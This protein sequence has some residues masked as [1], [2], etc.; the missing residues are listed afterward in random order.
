M[1]PFDVCLVLLGT[2]LL[3]AGGEALVRN[4]VRLARTWDVS[5]LVIGLTVVA[6]GTSSPELAATLNAAT[7][8]VPEIAL[9]N[10]IGSN[11]ANLGLIL[12][13]TA[14]VYP[15]R[16]Q[17]RFIRRE[18]PIMIGVSALLPVFLLNGVI[19]RLQGLLLLALLVPYLWVLLRSRE[20]VGVEAEFTQEY[21]RPTGSTWWPLMGTVVGIALLAV[22]AHSLVE[23][24]VN[25]ARTMGVPER[26]IGLTLVAFGTS[27]PELAAA[28]VAA[29]RREAGI[30]LGNL[31]GSNIFNVLVVLGTTAL[32]KPLTVPFNGIWI[33]LGVMLA[34]SLTVVPLLATGYRIGRLEGAVLLV[35]YLAYVGYLYR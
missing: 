22:G 2:L 19:G 10:V 17:A 5:P 24:G 30:V 15:I 13:I 4:A 20:P 34:L 23:G 31:I 28:L 21:D 16:T 35:A 6:F 8:G 25:I 33:D 11:I 1:A 9:G 14:L 12:G 32:I 7:R 26:V 29:I 27:L 3:Y 18:V